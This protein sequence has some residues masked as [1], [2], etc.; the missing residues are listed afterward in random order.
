MLHG[1]SDDHELELLQKLSMYFILIID[2]HSKFRVLIC[3]QL[4]TVALL[5]IEPLGSRIVGEK[6]KKS[7]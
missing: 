1:N 5:N 3:S 4:Y 7:Q 6:G 2:I